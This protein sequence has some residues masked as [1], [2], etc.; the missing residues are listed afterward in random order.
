MTK[1]QLVD[2]ATTQDREEFVMFSQTGRPSRFYHDPSSA[3]V[4]RLHKVIEALVQDGRWKATPYHYSTGS[5]Y[6]I[7][8]QAKPSHW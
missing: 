1:R 3:S 7:G 4:V 5:G 8:W 6:H 2:F